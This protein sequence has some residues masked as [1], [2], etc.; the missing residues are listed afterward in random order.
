MEMVTTVG[1][2]GHH[3]GVRRGR[4]VARGPRFADVGRGVVRDL[5]SRAG[6]A[7]GS[8]ALLKGHDAPQRRAHWATAPGKA[9]AAG[10]HSGIAMSIGALTTC[11]SS[12]AARGQVID[13]RSAEGAPPAAD[14]GVIRR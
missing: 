10:A 4:R 1:T 11:C 5:T 6:N 8:G 2:D 14:H 12:R 3:G 9:L 7:D 13:I